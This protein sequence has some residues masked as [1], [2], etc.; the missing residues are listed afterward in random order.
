MKVTLL[1]SMQVSI[2]GLCT[3][4]LAVG[5]STQAKETEQMMTSINS[6][7]K[8]KDE[9]I[10]SD[11]PVYHRA[12]RK[13]TKPS[14]V[15]SNVGKAKTGWMGAALLRGLVGLPQSNRLH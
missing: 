14:K 8:V 6:S 4:H 13:G 9:T 10:P 3:G 11:S 15:S 12:S 1:A 5:T 2:G 7:A